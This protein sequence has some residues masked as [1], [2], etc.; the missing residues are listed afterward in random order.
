[1][2]LS[3]KRRG[4]SGPT[5]GAMVGR[6]CGVVDMALI[7]DQGRGIGQ[8][9]PVVP[10]QIDD[11][12]NFSAKLDV[13]SSY[14]LSWASAAAGSAP[15]PGALTEFAQSKVASRGT[16]IAAGAWPPLKWK[17]RWVVRSPPAGT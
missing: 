15:V 8:P 4:S 11:C 16:E 3:V 6:L 5:I 10:R 2:P 17:M 14:S 1:M 7:V 9:E 13:C 12:P